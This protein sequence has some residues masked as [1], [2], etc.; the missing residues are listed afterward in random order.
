MPLQPP[1]R[2]A[3]GFFLAMTPPA[4]SPPAR[5][6]KSIWDAPTEE[7]AA[8]ADLH[9]RTLIGELLSHGS[10][11]SRPPRLDIIEPLFSPW[12]TVNLQGARSF[13]CKT[14]T[15]PG[16]EGS[17]GSATWQLQGLLMSSTAI[18]PVWGIAEH[19]EDVEQDTI[20]LFG[21][22]D[23]DNDSDGNSGDVDVVVAHVSAAAGPET[24]EIEIEEVDE[25]PPASGG[26]GAAPTRIRSREWEARKFL[27]KER[28]R[29]AR[30]KA[31]IAVRLARKEESRYYTQF[32]ELDDGESHFSDYDLTDD[33]DSGSDGE[34]SDGSV[35]R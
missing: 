21:G 35:E 20:S 18:S 16:A 9:R 7:W 1:K 6:T 30:L 26:A 5:W 11:F 4:L 15:A 8:W 32:G 28:V 12:V 25:M 3:A 10:W 14:P 31:Q 19:K 34:S 29:E 22:D 17:S 2:T 23:S 27:A 24:R 13:F 33:E